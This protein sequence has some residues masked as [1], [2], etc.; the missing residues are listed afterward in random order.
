[1]LRKVRVRIG[2]LSVL[3]A[4]A[5]LAAC[6]GSSL[7]AP[8]PPITT[9]TVTFELLSP[10]TPPP[11]GSLEQFN[12]SRC[13]RNRFLASGGQPFVTFGWVAGEFAM[14]PGGADR[15]TLTVADVPAGREHVLTVDDPNACA[16][17]PFI[18][19]T[20]EGVS[21]NGARLT[22]TTTFPFTTTPALLLSVSAEGTVSP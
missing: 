17:P 16:R 7:T 22:R 14:T 2:W 15:W 5:Y 4:P 12:W 18:S 3:L 21:A 6:A 20:L 9:A 8:D 19:Q 13:L 11:Q 1:M 10:P